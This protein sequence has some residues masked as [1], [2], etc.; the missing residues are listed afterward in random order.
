MSSATTGASAQPVLTLVSAST[1]SSTQSGEAATSSQHRHD[2]T[3]THRKSAEGE[4]AVKRVPETE[5]G[6][7]GHHHS[8]TYRKSE[9]EKEKHRHH[10]HH[11]KGEKRETHKHHR[12]HRKTEVVKVK[13][14]SA[15]EQPQ[16]SQQA[17]AQAEKITEQMPMV[18]DS[19]LSELSPLRK[20]RK[21]KWI[22][23]DN[24]SVGNTGSSKS[25]SRGRSSSS[26]SRSS[27][28]SGSGSRSRSS[29]SSSSSSYSRS[30]SRSRSRSRSGSRRRRRNAHR[31][32]SRS[33]S[34]SRNFWR[35][36]GRRANTTYELHQR[37][38]ERG[39]TDLDNP[40]PT[41]YVGNLDYETTAKEIYVE[42]L[43]IGPITY[44][45]VPLYPSDMSKG[46]GFVQYRNKVDAETAI[47]SMN[48]SRFRGRVINVRW[49]SR[50]AH[51]G[52]VDEYRPE[53]DGDP[54]DVRERVIRVSGNVSPERRGR[55]PRQAPEWRNRM[56]QDRGRDRS[57]S[58]SKSRSKSGSPRR[59]DKRAYT[60]TSPTTT[61]PQAQQRPVAVLPPQPPTNE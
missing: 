31:S 19:A 12:Q 30:N 51:R 34:P 13:E 37:G 57:R 21:H 60:P 6:H 16:P 56:Q 48:N 28:A 1:M 58:R 39:F 17:E 29:G 25:P 20:R 2:E 7:R 33:R 59:R 50:G 44:C 47:R 14:A 52:R 11:S 4:A 53:R 32:R 43:K 54:R 24:A 9:G 26:S 55:F 27:S 38:A 15:Q 40:E 46:F 23:E 5:S 36:N 10:R 41:V 42:F 35:G 45:V 61:E 22:L 18:V 8:R 49:A 3:R